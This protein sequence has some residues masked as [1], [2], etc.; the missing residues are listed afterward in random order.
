[1]GLLCLPERRVCDLAHEEWPAVSPSVLTD[2]SLRRGSPD[3]RLYT[4]LAIEVLVQH[5]LPLRVLSIQT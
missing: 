1:M 2:I 4:V 5:L 3:N